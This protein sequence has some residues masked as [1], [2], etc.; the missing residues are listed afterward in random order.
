MKGQ[1]PNVVS[2]AM[3]RKEYYEGRGRKNGMPRD[4]KPVHRRRDNNGAQPD[5]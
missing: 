2:T 3:T 5:A 4:W 1:D